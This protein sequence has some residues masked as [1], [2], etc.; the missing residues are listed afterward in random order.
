MCYTLNATIFS[1]ETESLLFLLQN[2]EEFLKMGWG[3]P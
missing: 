3:A 1:K 2:T